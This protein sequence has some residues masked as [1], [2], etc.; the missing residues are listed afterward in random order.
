M[1]N[2]IYIYISN[3]LNKEACFIFLQMRIPFLHQMSQSRQ[4][5][6]PQKMHP[7][8]NL[9]EFTGRLLV[10]CLQSRLSETFSQDF[11][12]VTKLLV[13][14]SAQPTTSVYT[15]LS[16]TESLLYLKE[17]LLDSCNVSQTNATY[18]TNSMVMIWLSCFKLKT[19]YSEKQS[20]V[21]SIESFS[22]PFCE[23][24]KDSNSSMEHGFTPQHPRHFPLCLDPRRL[25]SCHR[26]HLN[27]LGIQG[28]K[29]RKMAMKLKH[30]SWFRVFFC[31][32]LGGKEK[33]IR[34]KMQKLRGSF[35][36]VLRD[37]IAFGYVFS[38]PNHPAFGFLDALHVEHK[39]FVISQYP[40]Q[41]LPGPEEPK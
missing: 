2:N 3:I 23:N 27:S 35:S 37:P 10:F 38:L 11:H 20:K 21:P 22:I 34:L 19:T 16:P 40:H 4:E 30:Y 18:P 41:R 28:K 29:R 39:P 17:I 25:T 9:T 14:E 6:S 13:S 15:Y 36:N 7:K 12:V 32:C 5:I 8:K 26:N 1:K 24:L 31:F 33:I